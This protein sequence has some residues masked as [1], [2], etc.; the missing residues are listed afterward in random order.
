ML[1]MN[2]KS[3]DLKERGIRSKQNEFVRKERLNEETKPFQNHMEKK[4]K[5]N[6]FVAKTIKISTPKLKIKS[7]KH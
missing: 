1:R 6:F 7:Y 3:H 4:S 5:T 2:Y